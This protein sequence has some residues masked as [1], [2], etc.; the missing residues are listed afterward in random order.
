MSTLN[1]KKI[2]K[3]IK[4]ILLTLCYILNFVLGGCSSLKNLQI[5]EVDNFKVDIKK[6]FAFVQNLEVQY[7]DVF[8]FTYTL[9]KNLTR[10]DIENLGNETKIFFTNKSTLDKIKNLYDVDIMHNKKV[11]PLYPQVIIK[12]SPYE[13]DCE[14]FY[15][16]PDASKILDYTE[17][18]FS[19]N[20]NNL[21]KEK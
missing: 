20:L 15:R 19:D 16:T 14:S 2:T 10:S 17:W 6:K 21:K 18:N 7:G 12:F 13:I 4:F 1:N 8:L 11:N 5:T 9:E 3:N